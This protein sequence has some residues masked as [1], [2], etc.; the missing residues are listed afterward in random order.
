MSTIYIIV[1]SLLT[2]LTVNKLI[3]HAVTLIIQL[4]HNHNKQAVQEKRTTLMSCPFLG[5]GGRN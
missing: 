4:S 5:S 1:N 3:N 2:V